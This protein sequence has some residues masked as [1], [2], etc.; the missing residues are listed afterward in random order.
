MNQSIGRQTD[1]PDF[2]DD[3]EQFLKEQEENL[4][5]LDDIPS[6]KRAVAESL[7]Q[8]FDEEI[9]KHMFS[10]KWQHREKGY[11]MAN[12]Y[13]IS[14]LQKA[15]D[16]ATVQKI[17]YGVIQEGLM[18][19]IVQVNLKAMKMCETYL[20]TEISGNS[21]PL[22]EIT[23]FENIIVLVFDK[24][25]VSKMAKSAESLIM[26]MIESSL[27]NLESFVD[28]MFK[29]TSFLEEK[30]KKSYVHLLPRF[31]IIKTV[32]SNLRMLESSKRITKQNFPLK[33]LEDRIIDAVGTNS[34]ELRNLSKQLIVDMYTNF[35]YKNIEEFIQRLDIK[36]IAQ[37]A[38]ANKTP[39]IYEYL[40]L[41][42]GPA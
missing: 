40:K 39:E 26:K 17:L 13:T 24:L 11:E 14:I 2:G 21:K 41:A 15:D 29:P 30:C 10:S 27:V 35:G 12:G 20:S 1:K 16:V 6:N 28:F 33:H 34:K 38:D 31:R 23:D 9:I 42:E 25:A 18:D 37:F 4:K 19:K 22:N 8:I 3:P 32:I 5:E 7:G 36:F